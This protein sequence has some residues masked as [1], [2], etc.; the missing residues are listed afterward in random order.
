MKVVD[1]Y[2]YVGIFFLHDLDL[3]LAKGD[4]QNEDLGKK[5][6]DPYFSL[7]NFFKFLLFL[8]IYIICVV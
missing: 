3:A 6:K 8:Y 7:F 2:T 5:D 1:N 4:D